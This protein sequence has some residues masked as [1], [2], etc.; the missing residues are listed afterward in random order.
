MEWIIRQQGVDPVFHYLDDFLLVRLPGS[1]QCTTH[2]SIVLSV[3]VHLGIPVAQE[4]VEGPLMTITFLGIEIDTVAMQLH[5]LA[6][7]LAELCNLVKQWMQRKSCFKKDLQSLA[8][9]LQHAC[10]VVRLGR[11]FLR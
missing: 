10:K 4:K 8:G 2:L 6:N 11:T 3:F 5:L 9:K 7:K 1:G